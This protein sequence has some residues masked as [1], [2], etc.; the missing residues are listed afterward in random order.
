M[1]CLEWYMGVH[2]WQLIPQALSQVRDGKFDV[3]GIQIR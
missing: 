3:R 2:D 1:F